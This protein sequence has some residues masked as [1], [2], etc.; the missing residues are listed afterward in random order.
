MAHE[1][2]LS[3][4]KTSLLYLCLY[5][6]YKHFYSTTAELSGCKKRMWLIKTILLADPLQ[7]MSAQLLPTATTVLI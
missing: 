5:T 4:G 2:N 1:P 3:L 7:K 6:A